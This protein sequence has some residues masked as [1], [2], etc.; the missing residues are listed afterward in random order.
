M[1]SLT[2]LGLARLLRPRTFQTSICDVLMETSGTR[3]ARPERGRKRGR[4]LTSEKA[5][6]RVDIGWEMVA[7]GVVP[8]R[9]LLHRHARVSP[10]GT[11]PE[12]M[13]SSFFLGRGGGEKAKPDELSFWV[14][15]NR[16]T[17][18]FRPDFETGQRQSMWN[19]HRNG[20]F[21]PNRTRP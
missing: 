9:R 3:N 8:R 10:S 12:G 11:D 18:Q 17:F 1:S 15:P 4:H 16:T 20:P 14:R 6:E 5:V 13:R 19:G 21:G 2:T 7:V